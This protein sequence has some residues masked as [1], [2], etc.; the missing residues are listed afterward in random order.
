M[1]YGDEIMATGF[2][3]IIKQK[4]PESQVVIGDE[5]RQLGTFSE[6]FIGN[7]YISNPQR[8]SKQK[9]TIWINHSK[10]FRPYIDYKKTTEKAYAWN[11]NH[12]AIPGNLFFSKKELQ[13]A[14]N[15][16]ISILKKWDNKFKTKPKKI[17]FFENSFRVSKFTFKRDREK[18]MY[19]YNKHLPNNR[20]IQLIDNL[21]GYLFIQTIHED[22]FLIHREN[23]FHYASDFRRACA[24]LIYCDL[25]FGPEGGFHH[26]AAALN[27]KAV[28]IFGG[29]IH[30]SVTGYNFHRNIFVDNKGSPC[31]SRISCQH[32]EECIKQIDIFDLKNIITEI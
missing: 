20:L 18:A 28:V 21:K 9:R 25:Y 6:V 11:L 32:C 2:A 22:S 30:P 8:L 16:L 19:R 3:R 27:K 31:G 1:G 23:V 7:P 26:A 17:V 4:N 5:K 29:F 14:N 15:D 10:Y 13:T 12:K 24:I